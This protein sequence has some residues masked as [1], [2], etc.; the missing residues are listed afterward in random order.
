M[1]KVFNKI[2]S[3]ENAKSPKD[4]IDMNFAGL[5]DKYPTCDCFR[6]H[7]SDSSVGHHSNMQLVANNVTDAISKTGVCLDAIPYWVANVAALVVGMAITSRG[8]KILLES[9]TDP[10]SATEFLSDEVKKAVDDT[11]SIMKEITRIQN[12]HMEAGSAERM[13]FVAR[14]PRGRDSDS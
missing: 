10:K 3:E 14:E 4:G 11:M 12:N 5:G 9:D 7:K 13:G 6:R 1:N 2:L 8:A